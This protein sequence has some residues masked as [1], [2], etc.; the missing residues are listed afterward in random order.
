MLKI[1]F[2]LGSILILV[3]QGCPDPK[4]PIPTPIPT[5][6]KT[7]VNTTTPTIEVGIG[8]TRGAIEKYSIAPKGSYYYGQVVIEPQLTMEA[9]KGPEAQTF[10][11]HVFNVFSEKKK[12]FGLSVTPIVDGQRL[13]PI[14]LFNYAYDSASK[15][16]V[17]YLN[18]EPKTRMTLL[19]ADTSLSFEF[20]YIAIDGIQFN[21]LKDLTKN[22][23]GSSIVLSG[24]PIP[25]IDMITKQVSNLLSSSVSSSTVL[26][27]RPVS[28]AKKSVNYTI[29]TEEN[30]I[31]ATVKFSLLL[32]DSVISGAVVNSELN[33][34]PKVD[35]FTNPL[36]AVYTSHDNSFT[37]YDQLQRDESI[38]TFS[39]INIPSYFRDKC[40][41]ITN[42]LETY[43][44]NRFDRYNAFYQI[45]E[46]TDFFQKYNLFNSGC[47]SKNRLNLLTEMGIGF[48]PPASPILPPVEIS[49]ES[50][51]KLGSYML[52]PI[53]NVGFKSDLLKMFAD[54]LIVQSDELMNFESFRSE[55]GEAVLSAK[56]FMKALGEIGVARFG[57][58]NRQRK[59]FA[60]FFFRPLNSETL[61]RIKLNREKKWGRIRTVLIEAFIDDEI[62]STSKQR[63]NLRVAADITV[64]GYESDVMREDNKAVIALVN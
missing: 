56:E 15:T 17:T 53:A 49:D 42:R 55:D 38:A 58:Y 26:H 20:N 8:L 34:I 21:E 16:W 54:T 12:N 47:L 3:L 30:K 40:G 29:K 46:G 18:E 7:E 31:L 24:T 57:I 63:K 22:I 36:N 41:D 48:T 45:L 59:E 35:S 23:Y 10:F 25:Y 43:G 33:K 44:L 1:K 13:L 61:Y 60:R 52:N 14:V 64:L 2:V 9:L 4:P 6:I 11:D 50:I 51:T 39:Q 27:F 19:K 5:P 62:P 37:L 32:R 28:D